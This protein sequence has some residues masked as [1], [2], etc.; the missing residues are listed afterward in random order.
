[1]VE[2]DT[3]LFCCRCLYGLSIYGDFIARTGAGAEAGDG[4]VDADAAGGD[5]SLDFAT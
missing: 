1:V 2:Q 5:P 3:R 4:A